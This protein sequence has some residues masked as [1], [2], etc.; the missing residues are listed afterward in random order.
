MKFR[1]DLLITSL[2]IILA[3]SLGGCGVQNSK[4]P[5]QQLGPRTTA[6]IVKRHASNHQRLSQQNDSPEITMA[7]PV[8]AKTNNGTKIALTS[9]PVFTQRPVTPAINLANVYSG[10]P[11]RTEP[12]LA[13]APAKARPV[14][15]QV[16]TEQLPAEYCYYWVW[17]DGHGRTHNVNWDLNDYV[18][19]GTGQL[20]YR[21]FAY[22]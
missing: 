8:V 6:K 19:N 1:K 11:L 7:T 10:V 15:Y 13:P 16:A 9:Q 18:N 2:I 14:N 4:E 3:L 17:N 12:A 21:D 22:E 5:H 20:A